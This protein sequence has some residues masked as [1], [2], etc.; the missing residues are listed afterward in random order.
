MRP[1]DSA[2]DPFVRGARLFDGEKFFEAHEAW[3]ERWLVETDPAW[4]TFLQGLIQVAAGL[5]KRVVTGDR[6]SAVR[7]LGKGL[8]KLEACP[9]GIAAEALG[10]FCDGVRACAAA[11]ARESPDE[12]NERL[13]PLPVCGVLVPEL[14]DHE[15]L[16]GS[17]LDEKRHRDE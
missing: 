11:I 4:K 9:E 12:G 3:E 2:R 13:G 1:S 17:H 7:L 5:H 15:A 10:R 6:E 16:L 8:A 14:V